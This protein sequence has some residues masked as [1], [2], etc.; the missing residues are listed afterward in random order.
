[1]REGE[2]VHRLSALRTS[3]FSNGRGSCG[4]CSKTRYICAD[5]L[6]QAVLPE[7]NRMVSCLTF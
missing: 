7:R 5:L 2:A 4:T 1:M 3:D 6:E